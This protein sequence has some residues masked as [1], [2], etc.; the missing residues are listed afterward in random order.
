MCYAILWLLVRV[1]FM[2]GKT[3]TFL[4]VNLLKGDRKQLWVNPDCGL[5]TREWSQVCWPCPDAQTRWDLSV[6]GIA[7]RSALAACMGGLRQ[8]CCNL[9]LCLSMLSPRLV[10]LGT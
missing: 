3:Q 8:L 9:A 2:E 4:D 7:C 1:E 5:K 10:A 6:A